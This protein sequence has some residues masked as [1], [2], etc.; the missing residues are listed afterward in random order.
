MARTIFE[1][2]SALEYDL[3]APT[4]KT[5]VH[6]YWQGFKNAVTELY[7]S[8]TAF[9]GAIMLLILFT[10]S[11]ITPYID[12]YS[13]VKQNYRKLLKP[14]S[15]EHYFGTDRYGRD[16]WSRV[17]WGGRRLVVISVLAVVFGI[18]L[19]IPFGALSGYYGGWTDAVGMRIVDA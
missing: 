12:R 9:V 19:G 18:A 11:I 4:F 5:Y 10:A 3:R 16:I 15:A 6:R 13:P 1:A 14:P 17:L 2:E 7:K 8:K